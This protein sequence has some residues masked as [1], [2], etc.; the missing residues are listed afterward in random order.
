MRSTVVKHCSSAGV[1]GKYSSS[2]ERMEPER[3]A[4]A[5]GFVL[6]LQNTSRT[7]PRLCFTPNAALQRNA[8]SAAGCHEYPRC[9]LTASLITPTDGPSDSG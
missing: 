5:Q 3:R 8:F 6:N 1:T 7:F 4:V 2:V 9:I